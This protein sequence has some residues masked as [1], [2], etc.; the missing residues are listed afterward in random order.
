MNI[1]M[2]MS[3]S[4]R[5]TVSLQQRLT[6]MQSIQLQ[7]HELS[8]RLQLLETLHGIRYEPHAKCP[9]CTRKLT[10]LEII[11]GFISDPNDF[12]TE[13]TSCHHRFEPKLVN[14]GK[15]SRLEM[16]F[17]CGIQ[18]LERLPDIVELNPDELQKKHPTIYHSAM[19]HFGTLKT[20]F[21]KVD[22]VYPFDQV[23]EWQ[24]KVQDFLGKLPDTV[25]AQSVGKSRKTIGR[26][27]RRLE[28]PAYTKRN[29]LEEIED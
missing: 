13:C 20:A 28:I 5:Q 26:L 23:H 6:V 25:I 3:Q 14:F 16:P 4:L 24:E 8:V 18:V 19:I 12:T 1:G 15:A 11:K 27:R 9:K 7:S 17:Y 10:P 22:L 2:G 21:A 29:A